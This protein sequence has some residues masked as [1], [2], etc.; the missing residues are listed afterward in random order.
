MI[1]YRTLCLFNNPNNSSKSFSTLKIPALSNLRRTFPQGLHGIQSFFLTHREIIISVKGL[2]LV[3]GI[4]NSN[5]NFSAHL[6]YDILFYSYL[7]MLPFVLHPL[8]ELLEA[9][10]AA[11]VGEEGIMFVEKG[12]RDPSP[13]YGDL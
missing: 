1:Q 5:P 4:A 8:H 6:F 11:D 9:G 7:K 3:K 2:S 13:T 10:L 12:A